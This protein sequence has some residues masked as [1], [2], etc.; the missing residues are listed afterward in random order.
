M[1]CKLGLK[2]R[3]FGEYLCVQQQQPLLSFLFLY[4]SDECAYHDSKLQF[5]GCTH[6]DVFVLL[7]D[8]RLQVEL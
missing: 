2:L 6:V 1:G 5:T 3:L 7:D 4:S 8:E